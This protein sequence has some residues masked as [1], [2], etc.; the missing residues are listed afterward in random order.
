MTENDKLTTGYR[1]WEYA[2]IG[3]YHRNL[4]LSQAWTHT[5]LRKMAFVRNFIEKF[6]KGAVQ[7]LDAGC[8]EGMLVE[9][10]SKLGWQ[11]KG[12]DLNYESEYVKRGSVLSLPYP[13]NSFDLILF[14]DVFEHL[15]YADQPLALKE[16]YRVLKKGGQLVASIPN[17]AHLNSRFLMLFKG[18]LDR[19]DSE[20]N[21][22]G[23]RPFA[24]NRR[25]IENAGFIIC[26]IKGL[27]LTVPVI[28]RRIF[29]RRPTWFRWLHDLF[30]PFAVPSLSLINV[31]I[32][33]K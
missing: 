2:R 24:E 20:I 28:Y 23:E 12:I 11:I 13:P 14:L 27:T 19:T 9:D 31:F 10:F 18:L 8:G 29:C 1:G 17:Q 5:Y 33:Q 16:I 3:D 21:H 22:I 32:C 7:I 4:D 30:E 15:A 6:P 25:M 26:Q